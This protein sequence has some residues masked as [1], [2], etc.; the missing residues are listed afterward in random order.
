[1]SDD[2]ATRAGE[3]LAFWFGRP[4]RPGYLE[5]REAWFKKD[6]AF[7][8]RIRAGFTADYERAAAGEYDMLTTT[9]LGALAVTIVLDQFPRNMFRGTPRMYATDARAMEIARTAIAAGFDARLSVVE[10]KFFYLPFEH[11]EDIADQRR[12]LALMEAIEDD[13]D[14]EMS[15]EWMRKHL[16]I[17]ERFG[18]FPHRNAIL[19]R[20]STPEEL[21]FLEEPDSSF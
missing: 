5:P 11:S 20:A 18:R 7:D 13:P 6:E 16:V 1:M 19:G 14:K 9:P 8:E 12:C 4:D 10:R 21:A 17:I 15:V 2:P 3:I